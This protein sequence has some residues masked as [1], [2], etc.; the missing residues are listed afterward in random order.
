MAEM[1]KLLWI[2]QYVPYDEV[3]HAGGKTHNYYLKYIH[4]TEQFD[5]H[6]VSLAQASDSPHMDLDDYGI[7]H[8][9]KVVEGNIFQNM[10]R[11]VCNLNAATNVRHRLCGTIMSYQYQALKNRIYRYARN[12]TPEIVIMQWTGCAFL[13]PV[14]KKLFPNAKTVVIEEDVTFL[15]YERRYL[16]EKDSKKK[17]RLYQLYMREK[18][19]ELN[20]LGQCDLVVVN[21]HKDKQLLVTEGIAESCIYECMPFY[22]DFSSV[23]RKHLDSKV[24]FYGV[25]SREENQE[26]AK[27]LIQE[28]MPLLEDMDVRLEIIG[29][30]PTE[31]LRACANER[32]KV[33][34]YVKDVQKEFSDCICMAAPL[35]LGA[36]I[37]V[38]ILECMS[39]GVPVITTNV[40]IEGIPARDGEEYYHCEQPEE[41]AKV[42]RQLYDD[43]LEC[44]RIGENARQ[45]MKEQYNLD[46][47]LDELVTM[48]L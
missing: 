22:Q 12:H 35:H 26:C 42:I 46:R 18:Q 36:G 31:D 4:A 9:V 24:I 44:E 10:F 25:M 8:D 48:I 3:A 16:E 14:V 29:N 27:W 40:G 7:S 1:K 17:K 39:A 28:V 15:G 19:A 2:S 34:G 6:L 30:H 37:K 47:K 13:L 21:N 33:R 20:L 45:F 38:K 11:M 41:Y 23:E 5:I 43:A 32:I